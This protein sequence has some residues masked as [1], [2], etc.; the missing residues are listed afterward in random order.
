MHHLPP[1]VCLLHS[2]LALLS[3]AL[4]SHPQIL[5]CNPFVHFPAS[6]APL[7]FFQ[8]CF[9]CLL[10]LTRCSFPG[11]RVLPLLL[12]LL[13]CSPA[14]SRRSRRRGRPLRP[15]LPLPYPS[16]KC[17][18]SPSLP[19]LDARRCRS[20]AGELL[21]VRLEAGRADYKRRGS[22][23]GSRRRTER[24]GPDGLRRGQR[25]RRRAQSQERAHRGGPA[26]A[27]L[28][29][30]PRCLDPATPCGRCSPRAAP[31]CTC[32]PPAPSSCRDERGEQLRPGAPG[33]GPRRRCGSRPSP[34]FWEVT[35]REALSPR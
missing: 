24:L 22:R 17:C 11:L 21:F 15:A 33:P 13:L 7:V 32:R 29:S 27:L 34:R 18:G 9:L 28:A 35:G 6:H 4:P 8:P 19:P 1:S 23:R 3:C 25:T 2:R 20:A 5:T 12:S 16:W 10:K 14:L 26:P 30:W 31:H